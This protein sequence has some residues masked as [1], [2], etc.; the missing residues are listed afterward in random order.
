V[1]LLFTNPARTDLVAIARYI[2]RA[3]G[4]REVGLKFSR[5]LREHCE[6]LASLPAM[7]GRPRPD[8]GR[9]LRSFPFRNYLIVLRYEGDAIVVARI[10]HGR[11]AIA[12]LFGD[13]APPGES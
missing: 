10:L 11:R 1:R 12:A 2:T 5:E 13:E 3:S 6:K 4:H 7:V 8:L 9:D